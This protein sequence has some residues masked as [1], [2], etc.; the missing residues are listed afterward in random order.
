[1]GMKYQL[2]LFVPVVVLIAFLAPAVS[3]FVLGERN[4]QAIAMVTPLAVVGFLWQISL[5]LHKPLEILCRT[6][7]ML[8]GM[9]GALSVNIAGNYFLIPAFGF[10]VVAYVGIAASAAYLCF[11]LGLTPRAEFRR[12]VGI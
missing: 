3:R 1:M 8:L 2:L 11:V 7:R 10:T 12:Q 5:L 4:Q 6:K 9:A